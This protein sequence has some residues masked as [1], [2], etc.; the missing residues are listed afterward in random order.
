MGPRWAQGTGL[1]RRT[2]LRNC[3]LSQPRVLRQPFQA[4]DT[5]ISHRTLELLPMLQPECGMFTVQS[6][7]ALPRA[8]TTR[9]SSS[10]GL[11][12]RSQLPCSFWTKAWILISTTQLGVKQ[13]HL[14]VLLSSDVN[15]PTVHS[16]LWEVCNSQLRKSWILSLMSLWPNGML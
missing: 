5:S 15:E 11:D 1:G 14:S 7:S 12:L 2:P 4:L 8:P 13:S 9:Y 3:D 16:T 6:R 10:T